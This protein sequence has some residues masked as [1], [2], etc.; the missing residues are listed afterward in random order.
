LQA[1][2]IKIAFEAPTKSNATE[3]LHILHRLSAFKKHYIFSTIPSFEEN[4]CKFKLFGGRMRSTIKN[5]ENGTGKKNISFQRKDN[6]CFL[7]LAQLFEN[8]LINSC[9]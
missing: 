8:I 7:N 9:F 1:I 5:I 2:K 3:H 4:N 6:K